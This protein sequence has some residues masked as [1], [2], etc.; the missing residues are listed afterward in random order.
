MKIVNPATEE[1]IVTLE[2]SKPELVGRLYQEAKATQPDWY[3]TPLTE[4]LHVIHRFSELLD[5]EKERLAKILTQEMGKPI[6]QSHSEIQGGRA[7]IQY[8]LENAEKWLQDETVYHGVSMEERIV[9]E[10]LGVI[11]NI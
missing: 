11:A 10:P 8:F 7:R 2:V 5:Q 1:V 9:Y 3:Q 4:R 6:A